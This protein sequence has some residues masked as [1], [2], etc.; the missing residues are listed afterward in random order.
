[1]FRLISVVLLLPVLIIQGNGA[2]T[3]LRYEVNTEPEFSDSCPTSRSSADLRESISAQIRSIITEDILPAFR[4]ELGDCEKNPALSCN[5]IYSNR[6]TNTSGY[7]WLR[8]CD[9][10]SF[11]AY[12]AMSNPCGCSGNSGGW[13]RIAF[14]NMTDP[15]QPCP[16][17]TRLFRESN[18]IRTCARLTHGCIS[19][20]YDTDFMSYQHVC[21]RVIGYQHRSPDAFSP[22]NSDT[23]KTIDENYIDGV[24]ITY[25]HSPRKHIWSFAVGLD[26]TTTDNNRCPCANRNFPYNSKVPPFIGNDYFCET[27]SRMAVGTGFYAEDPVW[28]GEGCGAISTCCSFNNAPWFCKALP[29]TTRENIELRMCGDE[30]N[31]NENIPVQLIE[32]YVQ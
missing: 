8:K 30:D 12:C 20:M 6:S 23:A 28:D 13:R 11:R 10:S 31:E 3:P 29:Q 14:V 26:E 32:L 24:S 22:Y 4:C 5:H 21:G 17:G 15:F 25:G 16:G 2:I 18:P 19:L 27:G 7:Y 1:M 9:G